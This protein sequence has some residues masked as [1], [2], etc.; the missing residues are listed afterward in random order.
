[1][2][3]LQIVTT[4][5]GQLYVPLPKSINICRNT[6]FFL[7]AKAL[8]Q[9]GSSSAN[10]SR[11]KNQSIL[12][13]ISHLLHLRVTFPWRVDSRSS[14]AGRR[15][16]ACAEVGKEGVIMG[17]STTPCLPMLILWRLLTRCVSRIGCRF[18]HLAPC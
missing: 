10:S 5:H 12:M 15:A 11:F 1:M 14:R 8:T 7:S 3:Q 16:C 2:Q 18:R 13:L 17:L 9:I 4:L 6:K